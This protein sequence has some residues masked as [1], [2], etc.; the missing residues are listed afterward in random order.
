[1][2]TFPLRLSE[3]LK[4][5][6]SAQA[7]KAGVSLNQYIATVLAVHVGAQA[8]AEQY[9]AKRSARA[10]SGAAREIL[11]RSGRRKHPRAED[12]LDAD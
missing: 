7:A 12:R 2:T 8:E 10:K 3:E 9:F 5:L 6:A 1:M 11:T 4:A